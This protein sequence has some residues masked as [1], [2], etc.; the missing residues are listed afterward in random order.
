MCFKMHKISFCSCSM[1]LISSLY[2][3]KKKLPLNSEIFECVCL[4]A[5]L[6]CPACACALM[7]IWEALFYCYTTGLHGS[8]V[9]PPGNYTYQ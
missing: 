3:N 9:R 1:F 8:P 4:D 2:L 5:L 7:D 6:Q